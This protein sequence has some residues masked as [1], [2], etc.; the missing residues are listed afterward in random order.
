MPTIDA[1]VFDFDGLVL[2]TE[3]SVY[4]AWSEAFDAHGCGPLTLEEWSAEVGTA[5][6]LDMVAMMQSRATQPVDVDAMHTT[7]RARRDALLEREQLMPGVE[8]W[9]DDAREANLGIAIASSSPHEW[10]HGH[11]TRLGVR[12]RFGHLSCRD[13]IVPAKPAPDVYVRACDALGVEPRHALAVEDSPNGVTAAKTAGLRC[14]AVPNRVTAALDF[15]G[16]DL[17]V[18]SLADL[19]LASALERLGLVGLPGEPR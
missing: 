7:R 1:V 8:R 17:V 5:G 11:L 19:T 12:D 14:I 3:T 10:V 16:A 13:E 18:T 6:V 4:A 2:D 9:L 15:S